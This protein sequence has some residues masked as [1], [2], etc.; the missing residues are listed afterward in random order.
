[1]QNRV[2]HPM[3]E[4]VHWLPDSF[5]KDANDKVS[6]NEG[7]ST[8]ER[9]K[10]TEVEEFSAS[11][12]TAYFSKVGYGHEQKR[13]SIVSVSLNDEQ[14]QERK[15]WMNNISWL[16]KVQLSGARD[17]LDSVVVTSLSELSVH[18]VGR[19]IE[20]G[21]YANQQ[22]IVFQDGK[23]VSRL[24]TPKPKHF[25]Y[26][27]PTKHRW[28]TSINIDRYCPPVL[29]FLGQEIFESLPASY[30]TR[31]AIDGLAYMCPHIA[32]FGGDIDVNTVR[33]TLRL[34]DENK[35]FAQYFQYSGY[36]IE[37]SDKGSYLKDTIERFGSLQ[38]T[39]EFFRLKQNRDLFDQYRYTTD[40][41]ND[42][43]AF[44]L[45]TEK[46]A[47]LSL[48]AFS[49]TLGDSARA[50]ALI[51]ELTAKDILHRGFIF[52]C[53]RCRLAA[54]Y[55]LGEVSR[56]F[57]C[58]RCDFVQPLSQRSWKQTEEPRWYYRLVETVYLFYDSNSYL[59]A[60]ALAKLRQ[61]SKEA[62][63]YI[64]EANIK[65]YPKQGEQKEIDILAISDGKLILGECKDCKPKAKDLGK[66]Q[67]LQSKLKIKPDRFLLATTETAVSEEVNNKLAKIGNADVL[68]RSDLMEG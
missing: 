50:T 57:K 2:G 65:N 3:H 47:Y 44:H 36:D 23:S 51:D 62:F 4:G 67:W 5:L 33:P 9:E 6:A 12:I 7:R 17:F 45:D 46:R 38:A 54:W 66:Y 14:L 49:R 26:V 41:T 39:A 32:Y 58:K 13:I 55:G 29:P 10:F 40:T 35:I 25:S 27:D 48:D 11:M 56:E 31:V 21:N 53:F 24:N 68:L 8:E 64:C 52:H 37:L 60:L 59:T 30:D 16:S 22:D 42:D 28:I 43:V 18:C 34:V 63:H 15:L 61:Q 1:M 20:T 19:V